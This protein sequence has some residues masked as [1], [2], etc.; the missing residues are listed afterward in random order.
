MAE[1]APLLREYRVKSLIEGSNP[2]LSASYA[3]KPCLQGFFACEV[4]MHHVMDRARFSPA[5]RQTSRLLR[6]VLL[7]YLLV[8]S[9]CPLLRIILHVRCCFLAALRQWGLD[10]L[11]HVD[12]GV[13]LERRIQIALHSPASACIVIQDDMVNPVEAGGS[14]G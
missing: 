5:H 2:S 7:A 6:L 3:K 10:G 4:S 12:L 14:R 11:H 8:L 13:L 1:G 9:R